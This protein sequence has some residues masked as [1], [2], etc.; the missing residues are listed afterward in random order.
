MQEAGASCAP[1]APLAGQGPP[2]SRAGEA[3]ASP[4]AEGHRLLAVAS[5]AAV[6]AAWR[7]P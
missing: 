4:Q 3:G 1:H 6:Q 2:Q 5:D 7:P